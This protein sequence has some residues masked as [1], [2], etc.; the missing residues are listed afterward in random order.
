MSFL[1]YL[2]LVLDGARLDVETA[3]AAM[4]AIL[5]GEAEAAQ[6]GAFLAAL[7]VRGETAEEIRGFAEAMRANAVRVDPALGSRP[8]V[9]TCGTG[10]DGSGTFN[11]STVVAFV[12]AGA[13]VAVAK[14][15]NRS[16]SSRS[17]SADVLEALGVAVALKP[18]DVARS[19]RE[20]GIGFLFAPLFHPAMKH[21]QPVRAALKTRT[22]FNLL[23]PLVNPA[24]VTAELVGA[25]GP[26]EAR[27]MAAALAGMGLQHGY[28]V[29]GDDGLDEVSIAGPSLVLEVRDGG[30]QE[31][32][33]GPGDFGVQAAGIGELLGGGA[34]EN[35]AIARA[36]LA[37]ERGPRRDIVLVNAA[38]AL[39]AAG[40]AA[41]PGEGMKAA[42]G[43]ID[44]G[45]AGAK[46]GALAEFTF[47]RAAG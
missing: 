14:H 42:A 12:V 21:A 16:M 25:P 13:G 1:H 2:H 41:S 35:A 3:R 11:I 31:R 33:V 8:L 46:L 40:A 27:L 23:G 9:D 30:V 5:R 22:A 44:S 34:A 43:S 39:M 28:V 17:G 4:A 36:V 37:G 15:G 7:R 18:D 45:A 29:H 19:I 26:R 47:A 6:L 32:R 20:V 10:G 38:M 24:P